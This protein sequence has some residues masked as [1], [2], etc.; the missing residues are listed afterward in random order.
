[1][2][3]RV[4][5]QEILRNYR[6]FFR[7][8]I[9]ESE[10]KD[11]LLMSVI[12]VVLTA[13]F[14]L[15]E[16]VQQDLILDFQ[17]L[18]V[19]NLFSYAFVHRGLNHYAGNLVGYVTLVIP[20]YLLCIAAREKKFFRYTWLSFVLV[21][22]VAIAL[23]EVVSPV[24]PNTSAG[25]SGVASAFFGFLPISLVLSLRNRVS[26]QVQVA[27]AVVLFLLALCVVSFT[28]S[29]VSGMT[30]GAFVATI[31]LAV[32]YIYRTGVGEFRKVFADMASM[33]GYFEL[34]LF[35]LLFF[36]ASPAMIFPADISR[37]SGT[38]DIFAH[39][40]GLILGF[41][42]PLA[43][44]SYRNTGFEEVGIWQLES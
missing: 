3:F 41:F 33:E 15:P 17:N 44:L 31:L 27:H 1:M 35:S 23:I 39:Y 21:L 14:F 18:S 32:F 24:S 12:P 30:L 22:P 4:L 19:F 7:E 25:F 2:G 9:G 40:L 8:L 43:Y 29:G 37:A 13:I 38:V 10:F 36:L 26:K 11:V 16:P 34:V 6:E 5:F 28:Y 42:L 20:A